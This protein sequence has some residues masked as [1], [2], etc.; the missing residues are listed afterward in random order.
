[1][2]SRRPSRP[3]V[4]HV[5]YLGQSQPTPATRT[6]QIIHQTI[7]SLN[8]TIQARYQT[9]TYPDGTYLP[10]ASASQTAGVSSPFSTPMADPE[11]PSRTNAP[12]SPSIAD[13]LITALRPMFVAHQEST[14][15]RI[16]QIGSSIEKLGFIIGNLS[17][18]IKDLQREAQDR[19][20]GSAGMLERVHEVQLSTSQVLTVRLAKLE[21]MIGTSDD[22]DD[23]ESLLNR[24]DT[25]TYAVEELLERAKDPDAPRE[26]STLMAQSCHQY[27]SP[28][29]SVRCGVTA[30][31]WDLL[32][33]RFNY[34]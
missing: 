30:R 28:I 15:T 16:D 3:A 24:L 29:I 25:I 22:R 27:R 34:T 21:K 11:L 17:T 10:L 9:L 23:K 18:Q 1:M 32:Y 13:Y 14:S 33:Y 4:Q 8:S 12:S 5:P 6:P 31:V 2:T 7:P 20:Q 26:Y 19:T